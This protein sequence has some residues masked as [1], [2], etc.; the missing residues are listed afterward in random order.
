MHEDQHGNDWALYQTFLSMPLYSMVRFGRWEEILEEEKPPP[1][2]EY[3]SG[4]WHYARGMAYAHTGKVKAA[5]KELRTL[6]S[7]A[8]SPELEA[9]IVGFANGRKLLTV[10]SEILAGDLASVRGDHDDAL[11]HLER[12][13]RLQEG[14]GYT[15]PPDW[16]YP[17]RHS[18][19]AALLDAGRPAE[20]EVVYWRDLRQYPENGYSLFGLWQALRVQGRDEEAAVIEKRFEEA[21]SAGDARLTSSRF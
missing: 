15:E 7:M 19:G 18:L 8:E 16:Y 17:A 12:A 4:V 9:V 20:A 11:L 10:A 21:W 5:R 3:W 6:Q 1:S 2:S 13:V 14:L